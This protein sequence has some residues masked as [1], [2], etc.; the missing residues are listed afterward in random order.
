M[1]ARVRRSSRASLRPC[2]KRAVGPDI[3]ALAAGNARASVSLTGAE[4]VAWSVAGRELLWSGEPEHWAY[5]APILFPVVGAS[6]DGVVRVGGHAYPMPQH[7]FARTTPFTLVEERPNE[8]RLR[9]S[10]TSETRTHYPFAFRLDVTTTLTPESLA[11][12]FE[13]T[14]TGTKALPYAIG[15]HPAF[16]WPF[17]SASRE[18]HRVEFEHAEEP[19]L[20]VIASG[21]VIGRAMRPVPL[22]GRELALDPGLFDEALCFL[23]ARSRA[24]RFV[25]P[26][27]AAIVMEVDNFPHL[28]LWTKPTAP[29]L[30]LEAWSGHAEFEDSSGELQERPSITLLGPGTT[31]RHAATLR[32]Q[33]TGA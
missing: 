2:S 10:G 20:P 23:N 6:R 3:I 12:V 33:L 21:G 24:L 14:N 22:R 31:G 4:P 15:F 11:L 29:F 7:G 5:R 1:R 32:A 28:A 16:H 26:S 19:S 25:A 30:S 8:T 27:G 17:D 9:L 18:G 13:V